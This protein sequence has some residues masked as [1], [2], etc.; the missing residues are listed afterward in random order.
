MSYLFISDHD[1]G[2][3]PSRGVLLN[4]DNQRQLESTRD[5]KGYNTYKLNILIYF[6][7]LIYFYTFSK[8]IFMKKCKICY[9]TFIRK[10]SKSPHTGDL[11]LFVAKLLVKRYMCVLIM[12]HQKYFNQF[13][14]K[15]TIDYYTNIQYCRNIQ[16]WFHLLCK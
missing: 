12:L 15:Y 14:I 6:L 7:F 1:G 9:N 5:N 13:G 8:I 11:F 16:V 4:R 3:Q 2:Y 10:V